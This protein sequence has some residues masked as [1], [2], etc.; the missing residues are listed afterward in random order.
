MLPGLGVIG[1]HS[2]STWVPFSV[3]GTTRTSPTVAIGAGKTQEQLSGL[4][5]RSR[6]T[7]QDGGA[8]SGILLQKDH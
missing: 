2:S 1:S 6:D 8:S 7:K 4:I 3:S 5:T